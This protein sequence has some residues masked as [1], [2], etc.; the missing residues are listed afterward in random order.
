MNYFAFSG[1]RSGYRK[2]KLPE[3]VSTHVFPKDPTRR[4]LWIKAIPRSGFNPA[5]KAVVCS[6]HFEDSDFENSRKD[7]NPRRQLGELKIRRLKLD[8]V[9]RKF[10][11]LPGY[12]SSSRPKER[13][14]ASTRESR[15]QREVEKIEAKSCDFLLSDQISSHSSLKSLRSAD[16]PSSWNVITHESSDSILFE[17]ISF[18]EDGRPGFKFS[19]T[20]ESDLQVTI[21]ARGFKVP[22]KKIL[23]IVK[24]G[25]VERISDISNICA[26]LN[27]YADISPTADD[28]IE[29][30][31][32]K[33]ELV[34]QENDAEEVNISK[35]NFLTEQL[36][37]LKGTSQS[38]R[39]S[40]SFLWAAIT[41]QKTSP[42]LYKLLKEDGLMTLPSISYLKQLSGSFSLASGLSNSAVAYLEERLKTLSPK[43][44]TVALA[45]DEVCYNN[46]THGVYPLKF[47]LKLCSRNVTNNYSIFF[48]NM[49]FM[50]SVIYIISNVRHDVCVIYVVCVI[51]ISA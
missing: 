44:K 47:K 13:S 19:V 40:T 16:F 29:S 30:C 9:P 7:S 24:S 26:F 23:H 27:S 37:L 50:T 35:L 14:E 21:F 5:K 39:F 31:I 10:P 8:A 22:L 17:E 46:L 15:A 41:W 34:L 4:E 33:L 25:K 45:I 1:C 11:G 3:G 49:Y 20:V 48:T 2:E 6:L 18:D 42:A 36:R 43:E 51:G 38:N 12:L 32:A 28:V